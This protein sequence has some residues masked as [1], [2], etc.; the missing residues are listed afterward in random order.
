M[1]NTETFLEKTD[2]MLGVMATE[3]SVAGAS[4]VRNR[5]LG[6]LW[7]SGLGGSLLFSVSRP[8][9]DASVEA[10]AQSIVARHLERL[11]HRPAP[12]AMSDMVDF[13]RTLQRRSKV[14]SAIEMLTRG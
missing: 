12:W 10:E 1:T 9:A 8:P 2:R 13:Q 4:P 3:A 5:D 11:E 6:S 14:I 7:S